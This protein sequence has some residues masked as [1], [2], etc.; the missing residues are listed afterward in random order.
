MKLEQEYYSNEFSK[1]TGDIKKTWQL[2]KSIINVQETNVLIKELK[3]N[4]ITIE[5]PKIIAEKFNTYFI[6]LP[7]SLSLKIPKATKSFH[8]FMPSSTLNSMVVLPTDMQ[9][10]L[11]IN[12]TLKPTHSSGSDGLN[13]QIL[14]P[15][16]DLF[17]TPLAEL[18]NCSFRNGVV[19]LEIKM[20]KVTPIHKQGIKSEIS[21]YRPISV[22]TYFSKFFERAMYNRLF[23]FITHNK[24]LYPLQHGFQPGHSTSMSLLDI[25]DQ[26]S[27]AIDNNKFSIGIF[28][29]LAKAFDTVDHKILIAKLEHYGVRNIALDWFKSYLSSRYQQVSCN[30][31]L[32]S[33]QLFSLVFLKGRYLGLYYF[34]FISTT[35]LI[36]HL[37]YTLYYLQMIPMPLLHTPHMTT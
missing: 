37:S 6:E 16:L 31:N 34:L 2:I 19:P 30:G 22:L 10:P 17:A 21:N 12:K 4:G 18:I 33:L 27:K 25:Q 28:L 35:Y 5:D 7:K 9:E 3:I 24:L 32:S 36:H 23:S 14:S 26:I 29:D 15:L 8:S 1:N 11:S 20:A 13:P